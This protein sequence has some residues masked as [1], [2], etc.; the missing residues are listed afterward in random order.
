M[1]YLNIL[2]NNQAYS[3]HENWS[4]FR[5]WLI[6]EVQ[7]HYDD[8]QNC[9]I[10]A[11]LPLDPTVKPS[12]LGGINFKTDAEF[13]EYSMNLA[14][15]IWFCAIANLNGRIVVGFNTMTF[16]EKIWIEKIKTC[17]SVSV[18]HYRDRTFN[19][20]SKEEMNWPEFFKGL[21]EALLR[22]DKKVS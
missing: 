5:A 3:T 10:M 18:D 4:Q 16:G 21:S 12:F 1:S 22:E 11:F 14:D 7:D 15:N 17:F 2:L 9:N 13:R 20:V 6:Q 8:F 19:E